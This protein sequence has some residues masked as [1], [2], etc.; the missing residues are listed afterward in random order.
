MTDNDVQVLHVTTRTKRG[1]AA[2][3]LRADGL[4]P[5]VVYGSTHANTLVECEARALLL[6]YQASGDSSLVDLVI[7]QELPV[8]V[9]MQSLTRDV[10]TDRFEHV[11]FY[12]VSMSNLLQA[13]VTLHF[14]GIAP[15][16]KDLA[17]T[18]VK[19]KSTIRVKCLPQDLVKQLTVDI[20]SLKT[21][22][23][24]ITVKDIVMPSTLTVMDA[25]NDIIATVEQPRSEEELAALNQTVSEDVTKVEGVV[26]ESDTATKPESTKETKK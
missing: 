24:E 6:A 1:K 7:D 13:D 20:S 25:P 12:A 18:L 21:F 14:E 3:Q 17:G 23:D 26:K 19:S 10:L 15:A 8:K 11:D 22:E 9:L 2:K 5:G 16:V 4:V